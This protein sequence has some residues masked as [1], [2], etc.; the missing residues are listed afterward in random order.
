MSGVRSHALGL[1]SEDQ[2]RPRDEGV[3]AAVRQ[4][5]PG[6]DCAHGSAAESHRR[7][8]MVRIARRTPPSERGRGRDGSQT[9]PLPSP[10]FQSPSRDWLD[11]GH[12]RDGQRCAN[13]GLF[14]I[15]FSG[16][17]PA[18]RVTFLRHEF[19]TQK[20]VS[21]ILGALRAVRLLFLSRAPPGDSGSAP[22]LNAASGA[23]ATVNGAGRTRRK[24][25]PTMPGKSP[26]IACG[27]G[28][29]G[30]PA[31]GVGT[32]RAATRSVSKGMIC[33][34]YSRSLRYEI[35]A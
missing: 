19:I 6:S 13:D 4:R 17:N 9:R 15:G 34:P 12:S 5:S 35:P 10:V 18:W 8:A 22:G 14:R 3:A 1:G 24:T 2:G 26:A 25:S 16:A 31:T 20:K 27:T 29:K 21:H 28:A 23:S 33:G 7:G 30:I 11:H 32:E